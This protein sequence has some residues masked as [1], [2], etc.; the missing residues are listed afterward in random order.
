MVNGDAFS[1]QMQYHPTIS[2][3]DQGIYVG[4]Y[5]EL[6]LTGLKQQGEKEVAEIPPDADNASIATTSRS[7]M[8]VE[9]QVMVSIVYQFP[10]KWNISHPLKFYAIHV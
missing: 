5:H 7:S 10:V 6:A 4:S 9:R 1:A 3:D 2:F 8:K